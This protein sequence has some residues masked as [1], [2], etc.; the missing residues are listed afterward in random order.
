[1]RALLRVTV[2]VVLCWF[3]SSSRADVGL[4]P[5]TRFDLSAALGELRPVA[6][7]W[8]NPA[9]ST[10][11]YTFDFGPSDLWFVAMYYYDATGKQTWYVGQGTYT[12]TSTDERQAT[13]IIGRITSPLYIATGGQCLGCPFTHPATIVDSGLPQAEFVFFTSTDGEFRYNGQSTPIK[14]YDLL[15][16]RQQDLLEN[17]L[18]NQQ[19]V[20]VVRNIDFEGVTT[21]KTESSTA[22]YQKYPRLPN[23]NLADYNHR[24]PPAVVPGPV[25]FRI[26]C[27]F[28][29]HPVVTPTGRTLD[30]NGSAIYSASEASAFRKTLELLVTYDPSTRRYTAFELIDWGFIQGHPV[31]SGTYLYR[32]YDAELVDNGQTFIFRAPEY[33]SSG[34][35]H[36][37]TFEVR[38][39]KLPASFSPRTTSDNQ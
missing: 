5:D 33:I 23:E 22:T 25:Q 21:V 20:A 2:F 10:T 13:G 39:T 29:C 28:G 36:A 4:D 34:G 3:G 31:P 9:Q 18:L 27:T 14:A 32:A 17:L 24:L 19:W 11:G 1:M 26:R 38:L 6:G 35:F 16:Q 15:I 37:S 30:A 12:E 7:A 8:Y